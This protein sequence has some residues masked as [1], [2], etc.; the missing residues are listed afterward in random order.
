MTALNSD[1][2]QRYTVYVV[3]AFFMPMD[4]SMQGL[5]VCSWPLAL[6][7]S[8]GEPDDISG[9]LTETLAARS[10]TE[11]AVNHCDDRLHARGYVCRIDRLAERKPGVVRPVACDG[12]TAGTCHQLGL[13]IDGSTHHHQIR[14]E[15]GEGSN[16]GRVS[17][18]I[19][20]QVLLLRLLNGIDSGKGLGGNA[21]FHSV[22]DGVT[23]PG[24]G[25]RPQKDRQQNLN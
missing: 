13:I 18:G 20:D 25:E 10:A 6:K 2:C 23:G 15:G 9:S 7:A 11:T 1:I 24:H 5:F 17:F 22:N 8:P 21:L 14:L 4:H 19:V 12:P 3:I 16:I